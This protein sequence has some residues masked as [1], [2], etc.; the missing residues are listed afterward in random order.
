MNP[1]WQLSQRQREIALHLRRKMFTPKFFSGIVAILLIAFVVACAPV[2]MA[3][4]TAIAVP[5]S[6]IPQPTITALLP[7]PAATTITIPPTPTLKPITLKERK[8]IFEQV[9]ATVRDKYVYTDFRGVD[10]QKVHDE[11]APKVAATTTP[12]SFYILLEDMIEK[13]GDDH[14]YFESPQ[15]VAE[16]EQKESSTLVFGGIGA[17]IQEDGIILRILKNGPADLAGVKPFEIIKTIDG[18]AYTDKQAFGLGGP[19][20]AIRGPVGTRANLTIQSFD[21]KTRSVAIQ[22]QVVAGAD[23]D[24]PEVMRL[25]GTQVGILTI[26]TFAVN[27]MDTQIKTLL[28]KLGEGGPLDG[29]IIDLRTNDGGYVE[30]MLRTLGLVTAGGPIG[31]SSSR[32]STTSPVLVTRMLVTPLFQNVPIVVLTSRYTISAGEVFAAGMQSL[33]RARVVGTPSAGSTN[34]TKRYNFSDKSTLWLTYRSFHL[35]DGTSIQGHGV[36]P[37]RVVEPKWDVFGTM[38]DPQI[39]AALEELKKK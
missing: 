32:D 7:T 10:W 15:R 5:A 29:L 38:D 22:R 27:N 12:E 19:I 31:N 2:P 13:L 11:F 8:N 3:Q 17:Y 28:Q 30:I 24:A 35:L 20:T 23:V 16:R 9:W 26:K 6:P 25:P 14:A 18:V 36:Q 39:Q 37:D 1:Q 34:S 4:P 33:K 21:G